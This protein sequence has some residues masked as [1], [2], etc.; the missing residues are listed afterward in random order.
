MSEPDLQL[1][2]VPGTTP[3]PW[4]WDG[5]VDASRA[6]LLL[7]GWD[8]AWRDACPD[9][10]AAMAQMRRL[11]RAA[12]VTLPTLVVSHRSDTPR[13]RAGRGLAA[14]TPLPAPTVGGQSVKCLTAAGVDGFHGSPLDA[15]LRTSGRDTLVLA[16][17]GLEGP[18]HST[19]RSANDRGY[20]C[21]LVIDAC[22]SAAADPAVAAAARSSVEMSGG[23]FGAVGT[24]SA[25]LTVLHAL[26]GERS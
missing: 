24:A 12:G 10:D 3:Y 23:I 2:V 20:E 9:A 5:D 13:V 18:V 15:T 21:L 8:A 7:V 11:V 22:A 1:G 16:G 14:G 19:L 26:R 17:F 4:P 6:V 25:T